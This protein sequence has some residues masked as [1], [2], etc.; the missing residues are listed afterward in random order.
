MTAWQI[1]STEC[2]RCFLSVR[3]IL[4]RDFVMLFKQFKFGECLGFRVPSQHMEQQ[5]AF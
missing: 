5:L 1:Y 3:D 4:Y 2:H